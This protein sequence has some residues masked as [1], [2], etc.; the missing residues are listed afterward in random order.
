[1]EN[2]DLLN[3]IYNKV[4]KI[5]EDIGE[6]KVTSASHEVTLQTHVK[7]SDTLEALYKD[8]Q[9]K[10]IDPIKKDLNQIK[11]ASKVIMG[12]G[13]VISL[14]LGILKLFSKI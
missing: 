12:L 14:I 5:S 1:M 13:T 2:D 9:E 3:K 11:G 8:M 6:L 7:R 10:E 4:E